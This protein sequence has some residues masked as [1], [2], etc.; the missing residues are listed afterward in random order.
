[1][2]NKKAFL[3]PP[4]VALVLILAAHVASAQSTQCPL[5]LSDLPGVPELMGFRMGMSKDEVKDRVPQVVFGKTDDFGVSKTSINPDF[6][7]RINKSTFQGVRTVSLDF[8]DGRLSSLWLGYD[9]SFKWKTVPDFVKG[10]SAAM[11]LPE[12]W[13]SWRIRGERLRCS[14][15]QMTVIIV[16]EGP[17]FRIVDDKA[18]QTIAQRRAAKED[19]DSAAEEESRAEIVADRKNKVYYPHGCQPTTKIAE[20]DRVVFESHDAAQQAGYKPAK[21]CPAQ[22]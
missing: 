11:H 19:E 22:P 7:S 18:E 16:S 15:F 3:Y 21:D 2:R 1:M 10:I 6:D 4:S 14:D 20:T 13:S 12:A 5:K 9:S 8:L 17:S